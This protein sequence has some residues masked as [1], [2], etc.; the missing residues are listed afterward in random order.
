MTEMTRIIHGGRAFALLVGIAL[1]GVSSVTAQQKGQYQP[2]QYGLNAGVLP[3][4]GITY[5]NLELN[6]NA[7]QLNDA[8]GTDQ[9][10]RLV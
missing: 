10:Q 1:A 3:N 6:Y 9:D 8:S 7:G 2:G 5:M 4:P